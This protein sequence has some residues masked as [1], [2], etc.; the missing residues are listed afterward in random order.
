[1][2]WTALILLAFAMFGAY[3]FVD[4]LAPIKDLLQEYRGWSSSAFGAEEGA[5][6]FLNVY[7]CFLILAGI[8][9]DK[10]GIRYTA[11]LSG[12][13]MFAGACIKYYA[14]S[15]GFIGSNLEIWLIEN[16]N[17]LPG[18]HELGVSPFTREMPASAKLASIGFMIF[19]CGCE[20]AGITVSRGIVKW[21]KGSDMPLA[22]GVQVALARLGVSTCVI[23]SPYFARLGG[24]ISVSRPVAAGVVLLLITLIIFLVYFLM[25][26]TLDKQTAEEDEKEDEFKLR[27]LGKLATSGTFWTVALLC[28]LYYSAVNP[29]QKYA[30]NLLQ[31][32]LSFSDVAGGFWA[33]QWVIYLQ[34]A[35]TLVVAALSCVSNFIKSKKM[36]YLLNSLAIVFL[37]SYCYIGYCR[38]SAEEVFAVFPILAVAITPRLGKIVGT[39]G[40][41]VT[42]LI[43]GSLLLIVCHLS[44][45]FLLP[46]C[47][48]SVAIGYTVAY[49][50]I[51]LLGA[52]FSLVPASL[53]PAVPK[54]VDKNVLGSAYAVIFW[55]QNF[56]LWLF[57]MLYGKLL[58]VTNPKNTAATALDHT[59][60]LLMFAGLG[61]AA[62]LLAIILK[63]VDKKRGLGLESPLAKA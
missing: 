53:W 61:L 4:I 34:Y 24:E 29:F 7:I 22:M 47:K 63:V 40:K 23:F 10:I 17:Y 37:I 20:M 18:F 26:Y 31:C 57:P 55:L 45:A 46:M 2:R 3:L 28:M 33:Q 30:I 12:I 6:T 15:D 19:G 42:M 13:V 16:L 32:T 60:P 58:D 59:V 38:Q 48:G 43:L 50:T 11:V 49:L 5:E 39:H 8:I 1:M 62:I 41:I 35:I 54:L 25:D 52:S 36:E 27:D 9:L 51:L 44:F 56:G 21:F 14:V